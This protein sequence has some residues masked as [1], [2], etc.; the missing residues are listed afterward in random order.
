[1]PNPPEVND[2]V[3][4]YLKLKATEAS[5]VSESAFAIEDQLFESRKEELKKA[6]EEALRALTTAVR[7]DG[8][9]DE[10][11]AAFQEALAAQKSLDV[12]RAAS[13]RKREEVL[14]GNI[15]LQE[16]VDTQLRVCVGRLISLNVSFKRVIA[17]SWVT[18]EDA[19]RSVC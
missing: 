4:A 15:R 16:E 3:N 13:V 9:S 17:P 5:I 11:L 6:T 18:A 8:D 12:E 19:S 10:A 7:V 2:F 14:Q 1:M